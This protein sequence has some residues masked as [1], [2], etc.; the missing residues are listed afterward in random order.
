M[1]MGVDVFVCSFYLVDKVVA[2][3]SVSVSGLSFCLPSSG[4]K[5]NVFRCL[6]DLIQFDHIECD[7]HNAWSLLS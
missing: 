3:I 2:D 1:C 6:F 4:K 7:V 5:T